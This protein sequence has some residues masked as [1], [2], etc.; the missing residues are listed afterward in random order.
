[1]VD[2]MFRAIR[3]KQIIEMWEHTVFG[4]TIRFFNFEHRRLV[5]WLDPK[6]KVGDEVRTKMESGRIGCFE[7]SKIEPTGNPEDMFFADVKD[8]GYLNPDGVT[9]IME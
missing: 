2:N 1:M 3:H 4:N 7:I 6:P 9:H 5:G 8:L